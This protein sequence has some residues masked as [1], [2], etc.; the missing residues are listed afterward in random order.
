MLSGGMKVQMSL[1]GLVPHRL[2][3]QLALKSIDDC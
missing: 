2:S 1:A 3:S